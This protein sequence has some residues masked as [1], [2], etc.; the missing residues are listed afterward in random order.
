MPFNLKITFDGASVKVRKSNIMKDLGK[1]FLT[2]K[3]VVASMGPHFSFWKL[4]IL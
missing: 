3:G 2:K 1:Q 4:E